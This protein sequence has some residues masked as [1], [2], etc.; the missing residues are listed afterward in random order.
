MVIQDADVYLST[1]IQQISPF[2]MAKL[3]VDFSTVSIKW[4]RYF[5]RN[6]LYSSNTDNSVYSQ[7]EDVIYTVNYF[8][9]PNCI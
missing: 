8:Y 3:R 7:D 9:N 4:S 6:D 5:E 2:K 1:S